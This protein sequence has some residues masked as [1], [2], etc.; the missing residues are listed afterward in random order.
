MQVEVRNSRK[1]FAQSM[2]GRD[3]IIGLAKRDRYAFAGPNRV[4]LNLR[5]FYADVKHDDL[6]F[7]PP[8][9]FDE[10][11]KLNALG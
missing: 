5:D 7:T 6:D 10:L 8:P 2:N 3:Y 4:A 1:V 9:A 11:G